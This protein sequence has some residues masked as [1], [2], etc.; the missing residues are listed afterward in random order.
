M[1]NLPLLN[2]ICSKKKPILLSTGMANLVEVEESINFIISKGIREIVVFQCTTNYPTKLDEINLNVIETFKLRFPNLIIGFSD[3]STG[4]EASI[5]AV[6]KGVKVIEKHFILD[7]NM[8]GPDHKASMDPKELIRWVEAIRKTEIALGSFEKI[9]TKNELE[10]AKIARKSIVS[11]KELEKGVII[12]S[13]DIAIKR[14]G[15]GILPKYIDDVI[16]KR[17]KNTIPKD[18]VIKWEDLE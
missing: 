13:E 6:A 11:R 8:E 9:P 14:P 17:V 3:H 7:K 18:S 16:G 10:I 4:I 1:N 12:N 2:L 15:Y 5:G